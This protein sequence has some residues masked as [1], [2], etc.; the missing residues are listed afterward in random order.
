MS[1]NES[2]EA[3]Q[4]DGEREEA[5]EQQVAPSESD[6]QYDTVELQLG[7]C[8]FG[9]LDEPATLIA[10]HADGTGWIAVCEEHRQ[11]AEQEGFVVKDDA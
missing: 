7:T 5:D 9:G 4:Q 10:T 11:E 6:I 2:P 8:H 1:A 3:V